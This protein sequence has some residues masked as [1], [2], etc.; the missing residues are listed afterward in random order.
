MILRRLEQ[1]R[2]HQALAAVEKAL[3][4]GSSAL[5]RNDRKLYTTRAQ[6]LPAM[7]QNLG[8]AGA[9]A[10]L[11]GKQAEDGQAVDVRLAD[12]LAAWVLASEA[13]RAMGVPSAGDATSTSGAA[14]LLKA[15][16]GQETSGPVYHLAAREARLYAGWLKRLSKAQEAPPASGAAQAGAVAAGEEPSNG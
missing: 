8:L 3:G 4:S 6:N 16:S 7:I 2:A 10:F 15:I 12:D 13:G 5:S 9:L 14:Q 1:E 11:L